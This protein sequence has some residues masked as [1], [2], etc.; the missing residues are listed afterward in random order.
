MLKWGNWYGDWKGLST[1]RGVIR[2]AGSQG[3]S[4]SLSPNPRSI[5]PTRSSL[6]LPPAS[7]TLAHYSLLSF[8]PNLI[9]S[10]SIPTPHLTS[11]LNVTSYVMSPNR[12][13]LLSAFPLFWSSLIHSLMEIS[14]DLGV[15]VLAWLS[16]WILFAPRA[17][18][19]LA[20]NFQKTRC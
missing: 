18:Q 8:Q 1:N 14:I 10:S 20:N 12:N 13:C 9:L 19:F 3:E 4:V 2:G 6:S 7:K 5:W 11:I 17:M 16:T 15:K